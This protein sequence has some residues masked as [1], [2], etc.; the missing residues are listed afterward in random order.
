MTASFGPETLEQ[1]SVLEVETQ[2]HIA[3]RLSFV[4]A[5][6]VV[7]IAKLWKE[8]IAMLNVLMNALPRQQ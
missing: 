6:Q 3:Q 2:L 5:E 1:V 4:T 7:D 8:A